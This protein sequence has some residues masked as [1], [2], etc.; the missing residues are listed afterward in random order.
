[1]LDDNLMC[2]YLCQMCSSNYVLHVVQILSETTVLRSLLNVEVFFNVLTGLFCVMFCML[3][4]ASRCVP[5]WNKSDSGMII[6]L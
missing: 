5:D 2:M 1:M 6:I 4:L 3:P